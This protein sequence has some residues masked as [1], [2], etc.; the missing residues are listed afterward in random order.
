MIVR[1]NNLDEFRL[2]DMKCVHSSVGRYERS[3]SRSDKN[4]I[5]IPE[6]SRIFYTLFG[7]KIKKET[8]V[9]TSRVTTTRNGLW[10]PST[11]YYAAVHALVTFH[12][13]ESGAYTCSTDD[14]PTIF[15]CNFVCAVVDKCVHIIIIMY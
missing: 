5:I 9:T 10:R 3:S 8:D 2:Y 12:R 4:K 6:F 13:P 1:K 11:K 15:R 7:S 14:I